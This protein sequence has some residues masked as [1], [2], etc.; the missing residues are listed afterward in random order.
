MT[1]YPAVRYIYL[2]ESETPRHLYTLT[3]LYAQENVAEF[4][5]RQSF[6]TYTTVILFNETYEIT[7]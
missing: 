2:Y 5:G 6:K 7:I 4:C 3:R 1:W